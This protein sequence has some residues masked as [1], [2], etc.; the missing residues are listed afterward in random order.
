[1]T[2]T[3]YTLNAQ[4]YL[5]STPIIRGINGV[6]LADL[7]LKYYDGLSENYKKIIPLKKVFIPV[8]NQQ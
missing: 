3:N 5:Q 7:V 2:L 4:K 6:E 8:V 1:M